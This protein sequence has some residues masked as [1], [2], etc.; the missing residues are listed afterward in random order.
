MCFL[1]KLFI[2]RSDAGSVCSGSPITGGLM[3][4]SSLP[5]NSAALKEETPDGRKDAVQK[6][7]SP[8]PGTP[9]NGPESQQENKTGGIHKEAG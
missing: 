7:G 6:T 5:Q 3:S 2:R 4:Q 9:V 1:P 8:R